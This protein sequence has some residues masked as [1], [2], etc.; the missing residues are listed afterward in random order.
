MQPSESPF[1]VARMLGVWERFVEE[2]RLD[3]GADPVV[4]LSWQRC[5]PRLHPRRPPQ[6][7]YLSPSTLPLTS[8]QHSFLRLVARPVMEDIYQFMEGSGHLLVLTDSSGCIF[9]MLGDTGV[10]EHMRGLGFRPGAFLDE[11]RIGTNAFAVSLAESFPV[12]I[13]GPEHFLMDFHGLHSVAA[14]LHDPAGNPIGAIG[15]LRKL[16]LPLPPSLGIVFA[17]SKAIENQLQAEHFIREANAQT[18]EFNTTLDAISEGILAWSAQGIATHLN[19]RGGELLGIAPSQVVGRPLVDRITLPESISRAAGR[20]EELNDV[21]A[22]FKV[23]GQKHDVSVSLRV[24]RSPRG[25]AVAFITTL[26]PMAQVH[27]LVNR[28]LGSQAR[29]TL[30][31]IVGQGPAAQQMRRQAMAAIQSRDSILLMGEQGTGKNSL[32]RAI[33]NSGSRAA[34]PFL[35]INCHAIPRELVIDEFLG[36]EPGAFSNVTSTGQPSKFELADG[37]TLFIEEIDALPLEMQSILARILRSGEVVRLGGKRAMP[38][39]VRVLASTEF[40]LEER[41]RTGSFRADLFYLLNGCLI[42]L[43]PLR[44]RAEDIPLLIDHSLGRLRLQLG[45]AVSIS[46]AARHMLCAY[47]WPGNIAELESVMELASFNSD[48]QEIGVEHLAESL[49]GSAAKVLDRVPVATLQEMEKRTIA[50]TL[51]A[52]KGNLSK[53]AR[54]LAISRNTL[55]RKIKELDIPVPGGSGE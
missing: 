43:P 26:R 35:S 34:G 25:E 31:D 22:S 2:G 30:D 53:T 8:V 11:S 15:L 54:T 49:S 6:W 18:T 13:I 37:G 9:E 48:G 50:E 52:T 41:T 16:I 45:R 20:G 1:D 17:A 21:E 19:G 12:Q 44:D 36:F 7:A 33:H 3:P 14:P 40:S 24:I 5:A 39:D 51:R 46:Q 55:Y 4:S 38:V 27:Q 28:L 23:D 42:Q 29:L 32:A 10:E 47:A